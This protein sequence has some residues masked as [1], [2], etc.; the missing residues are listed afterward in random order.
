MQRFGKIIQQLNRRQKMETETFECSFKRAFEKDNGGV[1]VYV[2]KDDGTDMTIY[3]EALGASRWQK[4]A[5]LKVAA[6]PV[7]TSKTGKQYQTA[8]SIELLDGEVAVPGNNMVSNTG[9]KAVKD[10]SGQWKEKY[11]LT[12]SNLMSAWLSSGKEVTPEIHKNLDL[13]VRDILNS[14]MDSVDDLDEAP[15]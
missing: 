15:F 10:I 6:L 1:T 4:G 7:R 11:R 8:N 2:T 13:I 5:R 3:G 9:V 12:M 14:K